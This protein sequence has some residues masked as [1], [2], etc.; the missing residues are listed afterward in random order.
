M[1]MRELLKIK[2]V[3]V[4]GR[5]V[6][7]TALIYIL[8]NVVYG[9][10]YEKNHFNCHSSDFDFSIKSSVNPTMGC[11][12]YCFITA[13][14]FLYNEIGIASFTLYLKKTSI[15]E[16]FLVLENHIIPF[17]YKKCGVNTASVIS[18]QDI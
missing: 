10:S 5:L 8:F 12:K 4:Y 7:L 3:V 11:F 14:L 6:A 17:T 2:Q 13:Y 18:S 15:S 16:I 9:Y 1:Y